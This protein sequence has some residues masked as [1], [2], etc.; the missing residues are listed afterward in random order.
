M[1]KT[2][3]AIHAEAKEWAESVGD[4]ISY[5]ENVEQQRF[6]ELQSDNTAGVEFKEDGMDKDIV[7]SSIDA[8][9]DTIGVVKDRKRLELLDTIAEVQR[10][11]LE[12]EDVSKTCYL[13]LKTFARLILMSLAPFSRL[14][15]MWSLAASLMV[16]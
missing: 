6:K 10:K 1:E 7:S 2:E 4:A 14:R 12:T 3:S 5:T 8:V 13:L 9:K 15:R 16:Y 11:Y